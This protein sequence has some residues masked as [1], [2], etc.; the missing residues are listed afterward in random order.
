MAPDRGPSRQEMV[1]A[2]LLRLRERAIGFGYA[3]LRNFHAAED[4]YQ[5]A[6]L[7]VIRRIDEYTGS[8][9][10]AWFWTIL[11]NVVGSRIRSAR[12][13]PLLAD[14]E[15]LERLAGF[16][17]APVDPGREENADRLAACL[18]KLGGTMRLVLHW[19]FLEE[20][21][22]EEIAR[23]LG[24]TVQGAY[25]LIKRSRQALRECVQAQAH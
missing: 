11:R 6:A 5:E 13:A 20:A 19:R 21:D 10:D 4:A 9:F 8:G 3:V 7:V 17:V 1:M 14:A 16:A 18:R 25:G 15:I 23:R 12:R 22:C 2:D 24:R